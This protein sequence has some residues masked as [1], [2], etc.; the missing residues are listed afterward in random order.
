MVT[1]STY[2][3]VFY[4][5]TCVDDLSSKFP[6]IQAGLDYGNNLLADKNLNEKD[7]DQIEKDVD[8]LGI[9]FQNLKKNIN[10]EQER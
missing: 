4:F 10:D 8:R 2:F 5:Q 6:E 9:K 3:F 1:N 7:I